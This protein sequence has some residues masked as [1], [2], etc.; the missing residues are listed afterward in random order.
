ML[1]GLCGKSG[2]GKSTVA[3]YLVNSKSNIVHCDIDKIGHEVIT[4]DH[5]KKELVNC[6]GTTILS[7]GVIDRKKLGTLVFS[8]KTKMKELESITWKHM[9]VMINDFLNSNKNKTVILDWA[10]LYKTEYFNKCDLTVL[11]DIPYEIRK[12]R[13]IKRDMITEEKFDLREQAS[14]AYDASRFDLVLNDNIDELRKVLS[15]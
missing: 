8:S 2:S 11:I 9:Q 1:I 6:F 7:D 12:E 15:L 4:I 3:K 5:V 13:A 14:V 10:L